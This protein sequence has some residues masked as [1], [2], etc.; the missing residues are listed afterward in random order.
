MR[1]V[2]ILFLL[3]LFATLCKSKTVANSDSIYLEP[4]IPAQYEGGT[5]DLISYLSKKMADMAYVPADL[6]LK[7]IYIEA[8][9]N[10]AEGTEVGGTVKSEKLSTRMMHY[11]ANLKA[12]FTPTGEAK[13]TWHVDRSDLGD[14]VEG[15]FFEIQRNVTGSTASD[16]ANWT[17]ISA[18][19]KYEKNKDTYSYTDETLLSYY[20]GKGAAYRVRRG[21]TSM[22]QWKDGS[23]Y[24]QYKMSTLLKLPAVVEPTVQRGSQWNDEGHQVEFSFDFG[25][26][27]TDDE[28]HMIIRNAT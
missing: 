13:L 4:E 19:I 18:S 14:A 23:G 22:W 21:Y 16:D 11:P 17:T 28:G 20:K 2:H 1:K 3:L 8:K 24:D 26:P 9:L 27:P 15:D 10:D 12:E 6:P 7:D 5:L 25:F